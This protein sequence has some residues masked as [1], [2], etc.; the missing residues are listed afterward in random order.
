GKTD[1][2][3]LAELAAQQQTPANPQP[4]PRPLPKLAFMERFT[5][6][7]FAAIY[8]AAI[9]AMEECHAVAR[10]WGCEVKADPAK[11]AAANAASAHKPSILQDLEMG[12]PMEVDAQLVVPLELARLAGVETPTLDLTI[13]L[14]VE[15]A[16]AAG[17]YAG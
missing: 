15:R 9:R 4:S 13:A 16:R 8:A 1:E 12:K 14:A 2:E 3:V 6:E 10:A 11:R 7:G 17:L 5:D